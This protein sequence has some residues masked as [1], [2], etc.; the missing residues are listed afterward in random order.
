M[1]PEPDK[2]EELDDLETECRA[3]P[4]SD[5]VK[6][7][8]NEREASRPGALQVPYPAFAQSLSRG[9]CSGETIEAHF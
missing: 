8:R 4:L 9:V 5:D 7:A 2:R 3:S 1:A 6:A